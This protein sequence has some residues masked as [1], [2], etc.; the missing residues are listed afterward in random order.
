MKSVAIIILDAWDKH[1]CKSHTEIV[2][3]ISI[4]IN[5]FCTKYR[6]LG[7][8]IIHCPSD[9]ITFYKNYNAC[10]KVNSIPSQKINILNNTIFSKNPIVADPTTYGCLCDKPCMPRNKRVWTQQNNNIIIKD[11]D[12][13]IDDNENDLYKILNQKN[14]RTNI[15]RVSFKYV[16][17][18]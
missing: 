12:Y 14:N 3:K 1:W 10:T 5:N 6:D 9:C 16:H 15:C 18:K 4:E 7:A 17:I 2:K 13:I 11:D 8:T